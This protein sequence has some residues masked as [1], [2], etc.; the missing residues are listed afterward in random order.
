MPDVTRLLEQDHRKVEQLF[1]QIKETTGASRAD[2]VAELAADLRVH[3]QVEEM[4]VYPYINKNL[5]DGSDI[6]D[7]AV[8]EHEGARKVLA[9]VERLSPD[10]PGFDG[11]LEMLEAGISHHVEEEETEVFPEMRDTAPAEDLEALA[12]QVSL[13]KGRAGVD[14]PR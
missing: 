6:V 11:A 14:A 4:I 9:D 3:M 8:T 1:S 2:L 12:E 7:E 13:A 5:D 10:E